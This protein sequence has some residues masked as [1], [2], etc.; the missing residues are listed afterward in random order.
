MGAQAF[1]EGDLWLRQWR[2]VSEPT[3][4]LA[5]KVGWMLDETLSG[6]FVLRILGTANVYRGKTRTKV[7]ARFMVQAER[8]RWGGGG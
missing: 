4:W 7:H 1:T 8:L 6:E 2:K 3:E 5:A